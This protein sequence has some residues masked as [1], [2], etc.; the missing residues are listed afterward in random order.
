MGSPTAEFFYCVIIWQNCDE[1]RML[2]CAC[3]VDTVRVH[4]VQ[5]TSI[6]RPLFCFDYRSCDVQIII[7]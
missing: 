1:V 2:S 7:L 6:Y 3:F 4:Q 5:D